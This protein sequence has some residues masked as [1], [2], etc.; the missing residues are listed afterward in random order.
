MQSAQRVR[1][2]PDTTTHSP[3]R[4]CAILRVRVLRGRSASSRAREACLAPLVWSERADETAA[5]T[6]ARLVNAWTID[7]ERMQTRRRR[8]IAPVL[9]ICLARFRRG[10][11]GP[12]TK[13]LATTTFIRTSVGTVRDT[14]M[15]RA[16]ARATRTD[17]SV[18]LHRRKPIMGHV[19]D[20]AIMH[21]E[22]AAQRLLLAIP[23]R[24]SAAPRVRCRTRRD[25]T[26]RVNAQGQRWHNSRADLRHAVVP[27]NLDS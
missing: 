21:L 26:P 20:A 7:G 27:P 17:E 5:G 3:P 6:S 9:V 2:E 19:C 15:I 18:L 1:S 10:A 23:L 24:E 14:P 12:L 13:H 25:E 11:I 16:V 4:L 22:R 8:S